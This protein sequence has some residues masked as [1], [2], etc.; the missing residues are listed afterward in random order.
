EVDPMRR[1]LALVCVGLCVLVPLGCGEEA[2]EK[3]RARD[4][5]PPAVRK[6]ECRWATAA[7]RI[8]GKKDDIA[9]DNAHLLKNFSAYWLKRRG[10]TATRA[11]LLWDN[12]YLYFF[13]DMDDT[14][15]YADVKEHN[16]IT[17]ENDVFELFFKPADDKPAYYEFQVNA[18]NTHLELFL[19][20]RGA[21]G[22]RR[23]PDLT[24]L[25]IASAG[26]LRG[27]PHKRGA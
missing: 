16:G 14:D 5:G 6:A 8:D 9:W 17:W 23:C 19:P 26:A 4:D 13:A 7:I 27:A 10:K 3:P 24:K 2:E 11:R 21:G 20:S 22:Y 1:L 12:N 15:L 25:G 18:A